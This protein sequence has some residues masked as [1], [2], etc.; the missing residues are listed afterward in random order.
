M[1]MAAA[2]TDRRHVADIVSDVVSQSWW[3][4]PAPRL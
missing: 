2:V 3:L 4:C 1:N